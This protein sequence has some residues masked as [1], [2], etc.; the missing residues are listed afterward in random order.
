MKGLPAKATSKSMIVVLP[1]A[2]GH[3]EVQQD[4]ISNATN[5]LM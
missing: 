1:A 2:L 5:A 3:N 4:N